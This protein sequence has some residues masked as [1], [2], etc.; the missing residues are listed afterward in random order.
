[1]IPSWIVL[2]LKYG[3]TGVY[4]VRRALALIEEARTRLGNLSADRRRAEVAEIVTGNA[5]RSECQA[6]LRA[7]CDRVRAR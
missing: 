3:P 2:L 5:S 7:V 6:A 4:L 1:M